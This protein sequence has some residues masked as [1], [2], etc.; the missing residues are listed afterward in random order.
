MRYR[1]FDHTADILFKAYGKNLEE[2]FSNAA[3]ALFGVMID[4]KKV[5]TVITYTI[6]VKGKDEKALLYNFLEELLYLLDAKFFLLSSVKYL[7]LKN[8]TLEAEVVGDT[9]NDSY[10]VEG[11]EVKAVTYHDMKI[12]KNYVQVVLDI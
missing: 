2:Q 11:V 4:P 6:K 5:K 12:E 1:Y 7:T 8:G 10:N 9:I 3:L